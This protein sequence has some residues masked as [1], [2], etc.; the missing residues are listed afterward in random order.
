MGCLD[1]CDYHPIHVLVAPHSCKALQLGI[2]VIAGTVVAQRFIRRQEDHIGRFPPLAEL[3]ASAL[4]V[5]GLCIVL[6]IGWAVI[7][8]L[9]TAGSRSLCQSVAQFKDRWPFVILPFVCTLSIG[10]ISA[11]ASLLPWGWF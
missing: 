4:V 9:L 3:T 6:R 11:Y 1:S 5:V 2:A 7:P 10:L 8:D